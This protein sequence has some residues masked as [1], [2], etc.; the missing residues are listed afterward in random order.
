MPRRQN[1]QF[2]HSTATRGR[3]FRA[4]SARARGKLRGTMSESAAFSFSLVRGVAMSGI[5]VTY[6]EQLVRESSREVPVVK[7]KV[8]EL[9]LDRERLVVGICPETVCLFVCRAFL[10][11]SR[12]L[13]GEDRKP[14]EK[15]DR[16]SSPPVDSA[17][18][19]R[20]EGGPLLRASRTRADGT[21][22][23]AC[24]HSPSGHQA[25]NRRASTRR[26]DR[27]DPI[28]GRTQGRGRPRLPRETRRLSREF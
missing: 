23:A 7:L 27:P 10:W 24:T 5:Q 1:D 17:W 28:G 22:S 12:A 19:L 18:Q 2:G 20:R 6:L 21:F 3:S 14:Y 26:R 4:W 16:T 9:V 15:T 11:V 13:Q 8:E 25:G